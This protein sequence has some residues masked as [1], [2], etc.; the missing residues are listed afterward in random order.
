MDEVGEGCPI[1]DILSRCRTKGRSRSWAALKQR[2]HEPPRSP[3]CLRLVTTHCVVGKYRLFRT[4]N[5]SRA[6]RISTY[7]DAYR[8]ISAHI[9][10]YRRI[11]THIDAYRRISAFIGRISA[12]IDVYRSISTYID[13]YRRISTYIGVYRRISAYI[14]VYRRIKSK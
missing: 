10:V 14:G 13:V 11:S 1:W 4:I 2:T 12:Y 5:R 7:F 9:D 6:R 8:R 3:G